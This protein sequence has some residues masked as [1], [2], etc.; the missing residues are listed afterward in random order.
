MVMQHS[1]SNKFKFTL[2]QILCNYFSI[3]ESEQMAYNQKSIHV[4]TWLVV[5]N[6]LGIDTKYKDCTI[7]LE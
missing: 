1:N 3:I 6:W 4:D 5:G 7:P 2:L